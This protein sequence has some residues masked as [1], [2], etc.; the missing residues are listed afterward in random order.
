GY[1]E[2]LAADLRE[3]LF[4]EVSRKATVP[5]INLGSATNNPCQALADWHPMDTLEMPGAGGRLTLA[6]TWHP[7]AM[8]YSDA[9][10]ILHMAAMRGMRVTVLRPDAY[11]LPKAVVEKARQAAQTANGAVLETSDRSEA[12]DGAHVLYACSW[13]A[14]H[15]YCDQSTNAQL[16]EACKSWCID[17]R[18]FAGAQEDCRLM[19]SNAPRRNASVVDDVVDGPRNVRAVQARSLV[20]VQ[21]AV[22]YR[23]LVSNV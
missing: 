23:M 11:A 20:D 7:K 8:P 4:T 21:M 10:A 17:E 5:L 14:P 15:A 12:M 16:A 1:R 9:A 22:L 6:W 13:S 18:W 3:E 2:S 19:Q